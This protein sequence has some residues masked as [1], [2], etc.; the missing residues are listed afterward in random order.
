MIDE[1]FET[2]VH[3]NEVYEYISYGDFFG[4]EGDCVS[5]FDI[6]KKVSDML[7][8]STGCGLARFGRAR[9]RIIDADGARAFQ[10]KRYLSCLIHEGEEAF[11][12]L[13]DGE[14]Y[15]VTADLMIWKV[16][17]FRCPIDNV[18]ASVTLSKCKGA[19]VIIVE[20][21][22]MVNGERL[23]DFETDRLTAVYKVGSKLEVRGYVVKSQVYGQFDR[24]YVRMREHHRGIRFVDRVRA[25]DPYDPYVFEYL[26][27]NRIV[28]S[29]RV[30]DGV[31]NSADGFELG[32]TDAADGAG[33]FCI[34]GMVYLRPS[35]RQI[36]VKYKYDRMRA[37]QDF[38]PEEFHKCVKGDE[39]YDPITN[40]MNGRIEGVKTPVCKPRKERK[41]DADVIVHGYQSGNVVLNEADVK[42]NDTGM[43]DSKGAD[44]TIKRKDRAASNRRD[45]IV[46]GGKVRRGCNNSSASG[47][48]KIYDE[49]CN[50]GE[51]GDNTTMCVACSGS[52]CVPKRR[53]SYRKPRCNYRRGVRRRHNR[54][55][56]RRYDV[57]CGDNPS[58]G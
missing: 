34:N 41:K 25:F 40:T 38:S 47:G 12:V 13:C 29:C 6:K 14:M 53:M 9:S 16:S 49:R 31:V 4:E 8:R 52:G 55:R 58:D 27:Y 22:V 7:Q 1:E 3:E 51:S 11:V 24:T 44:V 50:E 35:Y 26:K 39:V 57:A 30:D 48:S 10:V 46:R 15:I 23:N 33:L 32:T 17:E 36:D 54:G 42:Y 43:K 28:L 5:S 37:L 56:C 2:D 20:D 45:R 19:R 18:V 21:V